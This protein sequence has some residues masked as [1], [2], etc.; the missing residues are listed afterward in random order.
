[1]WQV[2]YHIKLQHSQIELR[3]PILRVTSAKTA[4]SL[5]LPSAVALGK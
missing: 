3:Q 2:P 1:M 5:V 4:F